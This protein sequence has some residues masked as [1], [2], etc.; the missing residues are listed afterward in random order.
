[1]SMP[2]NAVGLFPDVGSSYFLPKLRGKLGIFLALT[3]F[4]LEGLD[5]KLA[6]LATH[7]IESSQ[8]N[9]LENELCECK[10]DEDVR[11]TLDKYSSCEH[12]ENSYFKNYIERINEC[13]TGSSVEQIISNLKRDN[14]VWAKDTLKLL[15]KQSPTSL[16]VTLKQM[17]NSKSLETLRECLKI[18]YRIVA[19]HLVDSDF[20]EGVRALLIEKDHK[21]KWNPVTLEEVTE[22]RVDKFSRKLSESDEILLGQYFPK[23]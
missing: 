12:L 8:L 13:F 1:M 20:Q 23:L 2:E 19:R 5:T 6:G 16:K 9:N 14:S 18:E 21:P 22:E 4:R 15:S 11:K 3:G 7:Y 17:D 10:T